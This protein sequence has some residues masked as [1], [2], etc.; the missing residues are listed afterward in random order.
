[1]RATNDRLAEKY[2]IVVARELA[3][4]LKGLHAAGIMHRDVKA[5]NVLIHENGALQ[6]CDFGVAA[7][8]EGSRD[9]RRTFI[10]TLHWMPPELWDDKPEYSDEVDVWGYGC[11][12]YE[13]ALGRPP[14]S[15]LRERQQLKMRMRRLKQSIS[16]PEKEDFSDGLRLLTQ[17]ALNPDAASRPSMQDVLQHEYLS[18]TE[19]RY[20]TKS[21]SELVQHYYTWLFG[22][23]Q[24]VS[25]FMPGGAAAAHV[26]DDDWAGL[27]ESSEWDFSVTQDFEKRVSAIL[28]I[29][30]FSDFSDTDYFEGESTPRQIIKPTG[31][32]PPKEM[33]AAQRANFEL[34]VQR[35]EGLNNLFD[36]ARPAYEYK[37]KTDFIPV[38]TERR[39]SDLPLRAMAEDRP[40][41][42]ASNVIDLGDFDSDDYA[43]VAPKTDDH[44]QTGYA[45]PPAKEE[46]GF[47][48]ADAATIRAKRADSK[49]PRDA[50]NSSA[51]RALAQRDVVDISKNVSIHDFAAQPQDHTI[52]SIVPVLQEAAEITPTANGPRNTMQ[53]SFASAMSELSGND[54]DP[55]PMS[56]DSFQSLPEEDGFGATI[57]EQ[58]IEVKARKHATLDWSFTDAMAQVADE[59]KDEV[60]VHNSTTPR[61]P[62]PMLR[63]MTQ[64]I[65]RHEVNEAID[66]DLPGRPDTA[67]SFTYSESSQSSTD[68]DP[69][70]LDRHED[71]SG[72]IH[73][74]LDELGV[75]TFYT[76]R[77][78]HITQLSQTSLNG[79]GPE[80]D[81]MGMTITKEPPFLLQHPTRLDSHQD[82]FNQ[83]QTITARRLGHIRGNGSNSSQGSTGT[84]NIPAT[85]S[86]V[87]SGPGPVER[88]RSMTR[89]SHMQQS[90]ISSTSTRISAFGRFNFPDPKPPSIAALSTDADPDVVEREL[91]RLLGE[92]QGALGAMGEVLEDRSRGR[93]LKRSDIHS[94]HGPPKMNGM[95]GNGRLVGLNLH[96]ESEWEDLSG[97]EEGPE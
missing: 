76:T 8:L 30:D 41:S 46:I 50:R 24:R 64:P 96:S 10:G 45:G 68:F 16:L 48:L 63:T 80:E 55:E 78:R 17:F 38:Q 74:E 92:F 81:G 66:D 87:A 52:K 2:L 73:Q 25:L 42:I 56:D 77:G 29:P 32:S 20:P 22:G 62:A 14:N 43:I 93:T 39:I 31:I 1:M 3:K 21:L 47:K 26:G 36:Q 95:N 70:A 94:T 18:E 79:P 72:L 97:I 44:I 6:L 69:F 61:R 7:T 23:G 86:T 60:P 58:P 54:D 49:G 53:W 11:T 9:K 4:A 65:T 57:R 13:C 91:E 59:E 35:G 12:I 89:D 34:R 85:P 15:D 5:A 33:S 67:L 88:G 51:T 28:E 19:E 75:G 37:T 83:G 40:S 27:T 90:S 84:S 82:D 71:P